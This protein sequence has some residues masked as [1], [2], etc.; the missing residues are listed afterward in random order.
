MNTFKNY[1]DECDDMDQVE[2]PVAD[3]TKGQKVEEGETFIDPEPWPEPVDG[4]A[5]IA[6]IINVIRRHTIM[7]VREQLA[8]ALW[9]IYSYCHDLWRHSPFLGFQSPTMRCG[10]TTALGV[11]SALVPRPMAMANV[12][13]AG[14]F[15]LI[16][17]HAPTVMIDE[18]DQAI[19]R[20]K[21]L[22]LVLNTAHN[23]LTAF[24]PRVLNGVAQR[25]RVFSPKVMAC[26]GKLPDTLQDRSIVINLR[27]KRP[28]EVVELMPNDPVAVYVDVTRRI[29]RWVKDNRPVMGTLQPTI[30]SG[31]SD[32]AADNWRPLLAI[33]DVLG[34]QWASEARISALEISRA[35]DIESVD[36]AEQLIRDIERVFN[37]SR[38][39]KQLPV[40]RLHAALVAIDGGMWAEFERGQP[41]SKARLGRVLNPFGIRSAVV[42][43]RGKVTR[44][45]WR[46]DFADTFGRYCTTNAA[47]ERTV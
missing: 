31:M 16:H 29:S 42:R 19:H 40:D 41:L 35:A 4:N 27:R 30:P 46:A 33:A 20:N 15:R 12:T 23:S 26:I 45:Y 11:V 17:D 34:P 3:V 6:E 1:D 38:G 13:G 22:R 43:L 18:L 39:A 44:V 37:D 5:L 2:N 25:F 47:P 14:L 7:N 24:V 32:R 9:V 21:D 36:P 10:K 28:D 8:V